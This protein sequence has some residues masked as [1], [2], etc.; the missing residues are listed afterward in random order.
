M[1]Y[2]KCGRV[3]VTQNSNTAISNVGPSKIASFSTSLAL[4]LVSLKASIVATESGSGTKSPTNPYTLGG[5]SNAVIY[6]YGQNMF[7]VSTATIIGSRLLNYE[8]G[9]LS[10]WGS[11]WSALETYVDIPSNAQ[12]Q[13]YSAT[14]FVAGGNAGVCF[15]D[16]NKTFISGLQY[17]SGFIG[18]TLSFTTP[19]NAKYM[20]W[21]GSGN[22]VTDSV[23]SATATA[24]EAYNPN[25]TQTTLALGQTVYGGE[26]VLTKKASGYGVKL[27]VTHGII[28]LDGTQ[29]IA[30]VNWRP[31]TNSVGFY[32]NNLLTDGKTEPTI[33]SKTLKNVSDKLDYVTYNTIF[34]NDTNSFALITTSGYKRLVVRVDNTSLTTIDATNA[35]LA[36]NPITII[37]ELATPI[38]IDLTDA[39]DIVALVG[40]NNVWSDTGDMEVE[41]Y[42]NIS[43]NLEQTS[44]SRAIMKAE[45]ELKEK[46]EKELK[47][48]VKE[49]IIEPIKDEGELKK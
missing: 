44:K 11:G 26:I 49:P 47:E 35:W 32:Y 42:A 7:D 41:Y 2:Y 10:A 15:Y 31:K 21:C 39:S 40:V 27:R 48:I 37:Y 45:K 20:R 4:P 13:L 28:T 34:D 23:L 8:T 43:D 25:S 5:F 24:F 22:A 33:N 29:D 38:E 9:N 46:Q 3:Y 36:Q 19:A 14:G 12:L 16:R 17:K 1:A 6:R 30:N 18:N